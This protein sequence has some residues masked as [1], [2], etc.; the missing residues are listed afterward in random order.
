MRGISW[1]RSVIVVVSVVRRTRQNRFFTFCLRPRVFLCVR[2][3]FSASVLTFS[4]QQKKIQRTC[5]LRR[6][7]TAKFE[8]EKS[9]FDISMFGAPGANGFSSE[10]FCAKNRFCRDNVAS[11]VRMIP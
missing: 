2:S 3:R 5:R 4:Q 6:G 10:K 8:F 1:S 9:N 7:K 11:D